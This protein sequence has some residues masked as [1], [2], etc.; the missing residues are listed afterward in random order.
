MFYFREEVRSLVAVAFGH[1]EFWRWRL[2]LVVAHGQIMGFCWLVGV[3]RLRGAFC[4]SVLHEFFRVHELYLQVVLL[5]NKL[6]L[7]WV[8]F[9]VKIGVQS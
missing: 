7:V 3:F 5:F 8:V 4:L 2:V 1:Y 9:F 6:F